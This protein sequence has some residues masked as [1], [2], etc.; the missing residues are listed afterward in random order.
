M[1]SS[2]VEMLLSLFSHR[3]GPADRL[4]PKFGIHYLWFHVPR[5]GPRIHLQPSTTIYIL[6]SCLLW[7]RY[8]CRY[9]LDQSFVWSISPNDKRQT[10]LITLPIAYIAKALIYRY[11]FGAER[12]LNG[13]NVYGRHSKA[14]PVDQVP[15]FCSMGT[16]SMFNVQ[17]SMHYF[18]YH[19]R[20]FPSDVHRDGIFLLVDYFVYYCI[21]NTTTH[22]KQQGSD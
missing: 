8:R 9:G 15:V 3:L 17:C 19:P 18:Q 10:T 14:R 2:P 22:I 21:P 13:T 20:A 11:S 6:P 1:S 4:A 16:C 12:P 7:V 5:N